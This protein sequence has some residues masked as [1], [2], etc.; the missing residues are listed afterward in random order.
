MLHYS[1]GHQVLG[2]GSIWVERSLPLAH[3]PRGRYMHLELVGPSL[4]ALSVIISVTMLMQR[5]CLPSPGG[6]TLGGSQRIR[7]IHT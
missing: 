7:C 5:I 6:P 1:P 2:S 3:R 4:N